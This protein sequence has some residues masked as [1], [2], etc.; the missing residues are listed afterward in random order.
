MSEPAPR[1]NT[2]LIVSLCV[3][4]LLAGVIAMA[5]FRFFPQENATTAVNVPPPGSPERAQVRQLM[6]PKFL[7]QVSPESA[8]RIRDIVDAHREKLDHLRVEAQ[9]A[10][11]EIL[12][13]F[14]AP[15][16]DKAALDKALTR[17]Q[18]ADA[19]V[20][21]EI[22]RAMAETATILTPEE[23]KKAAEWRG[24]HGGGLMGFQ[25]GGHDRDHGPRP[26]NH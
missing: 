9:A 6:S 11:R 5:A 13:T 1:F 22:L 15:Q 24:H 26:D 23:R 8:D 14:G 2:A 25:P 12:I 17:M 3:N 16:L 7:S 21:A 18:V 19:A 20:Q 10:R 4:L